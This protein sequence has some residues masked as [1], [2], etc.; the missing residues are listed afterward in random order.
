MAKSW[1]ATWGLKFTIKH[2]FSC[3]IKETSQ[4]FVQ[5]HHSPEAM[6][7]ECA[8]D[9]ASPIKRSTLGIFAITSP[10]KSVFCCSSVF[11]HPFLFSYPLIHG[12]AK[13]EGL[14]GVV[15]AQ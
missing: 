11:D 4:R 15:R 9:R 14:K 10:S 2:A 8:S 3:D 13:Q 7:E 1:E 5:T 6:F 12:P